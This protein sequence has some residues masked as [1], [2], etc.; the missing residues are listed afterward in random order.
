MSRTTPPAV[1]STSLPGRDVPR[2]HARGRN[3][4]KSPHT[5]TL[6]GPDFS[7]ALRLFPYEN[8]GP[9]AFGVLVACSAC[10]ARSAITTNTAERRTP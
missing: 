1:F 4:H 5:G 2:D 6:R 9:L 3:G 8:S 7:T 10:R